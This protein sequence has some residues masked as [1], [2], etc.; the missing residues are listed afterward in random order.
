MYKKSIRRLNS[1]NVENKISKYV[2]VPSMKE[3]EAKAIEAMGWSHAQYML[4]LLKARVKC[5]CNSW[6]Y[7]LS[8]MYEYPEEKLGMF[9]T[10]FMKDM[11]VTRYIDWENRSYKAFKDKQ[12]FYRLFKDF[13]HRDW[14]VSD[15]LDE[16]TFLKRISTWGN[17]LVYKPEEALKGIGIRKFTINESEEQNREVY[18]EIASS[19]R[20]LIEQCIV[21]HETLAAFY[22]GAVSSIRIVTLRH[23]DDVSFL[24]GMFRTGKSGVV[25]NWSQGGVCAGV[26]METGEIRTRGLLHNGDL[27]DTHPATGV[28]FKGTMIPYWDKVREE[29]TKAAKVVENNPLVGWDVTVSPE[30]EVVFIEG[31]HSPG[32][33]GMQAVQSADL[34]LGL[35]ERYRPF[36]YFDE[37]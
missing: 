25:D 16:E 32:V 37:K 8:R 5:G 28:V 12:E 31:N 24:A 33:I 35:E 21:Q 34:G 6:E 20:A 27:V 18:K 29:C 1:L 15:E 14:F 2:I 9:V 17:A 3:Y 36:L 7:M 26:D 11:M 19:P 10:T 23:G 4:H 22:P 13:I 30:G